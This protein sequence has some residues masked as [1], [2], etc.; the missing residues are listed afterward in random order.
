MKANRKDNTDFQL[1]SNIIRGDIKSFDVLFERYY[2]LLFTFV[3]RMLKDREAAED[4]TQ[5][6]FIKLWL[7]RDRLKPELPV[8]NILYKIIRNSCLDYFRSKK[9]VLKSLVS[10]LGTELTDSA[11]ADEMLSYH[12]TNDILL[13]QVSQF[14]EKRRTVFEMSRYLNMSNRDIAERLNISERTVEKHIQLALRD[15]RGKIS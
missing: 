4:I 14:P 15:L 7:Y 13:R 9:E 3:L 6:C 11:K 2:P 8:K 10:S 12:Q 5:E 1:V